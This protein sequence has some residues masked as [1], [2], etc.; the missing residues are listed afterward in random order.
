MR[1][2]TCVCC[3]REIPEGL[4][5]CKFCETSA[6]KTT[7]VKDHTKLLRAVR[8]VLCLSVITA[9]VFVAIFNK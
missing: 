1:E 2:N 7:E 8:L 9:A 5:V 3:G 4:Q 6:S